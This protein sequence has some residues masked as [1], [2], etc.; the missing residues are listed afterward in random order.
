M[1]SAREVTEELGCMWWC[2]VIQRCEWCMSWGGAGFWWAE[3][4]TLSMERRLNVNIVFMF[5][6]PALTA[7]DSRPMPG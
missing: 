3:S 6:M 2:M 5:P 1:M 7:L 4:F